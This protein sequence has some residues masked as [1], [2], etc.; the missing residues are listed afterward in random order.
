MVLSQQGV[1]LLVEVF[2]VGMQAE[3]L[4]GAVLQEGVFM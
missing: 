3:I 2:D 1:P 4:C